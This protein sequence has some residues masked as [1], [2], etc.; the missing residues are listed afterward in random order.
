[1]ASP[2]RHQGLADL[3]KGTA[4]QFVQLVG[5]QAKLV[6]LEFR[7]DVRSLGDKFARVALVVPLVFMGYTFVMAGTTVAL[8]RLIGIMLALFV[9]GGAHLIVGAAL[10]I[11]ALGQIKRLA[12][13][14]RSREE[15]AHSAKS[16]ANAAS[17]PETG[18][19]NLVTRESTHA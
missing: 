16:V 9:V 7:E 5:S 19:I 8:G 18:S 13:L 14:D 2:E 3:L 15:F 12:L 1:M 10:T 11:A 6:R 17:P 4:E